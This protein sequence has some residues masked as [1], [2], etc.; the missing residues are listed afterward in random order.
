M[1]LI[2]SKECDDLLLK[3]PVIYLHKVNCMQIIILSMLHQSMS[4]NKL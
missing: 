1:V 2:I 3:I 4:L